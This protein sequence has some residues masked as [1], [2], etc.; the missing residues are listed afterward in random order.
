MAPLG[1]S[2]SDNYR[3]LV[4]LVRSKSLQ[5]PDHICF[6]YL[7]GGGR[8][9]I[10]LTYRQIDKMAMVIAARLQQVCAPGE[11]VLL[12]YPSGLD[13]IP[14][15][16][17]CLYAG[18]IAVPC[19]PPKSKSDLSTLQR[20]A[21]D[22]NSHL[23]LTNQ[24]ILKNDQLQLDQAT[25]LNNLAWI[26]TDQIFGEEIT[27]GWKEADISGNTIACIMYTSGSTR[28]P[29]GVMLTHDN[30]LK[31]GT[32][33]LHDFE[34]GEKDILLCWVSYY[35]VMGL[36]SA[37]LVPI[38]RDIPVILFPPESFAE[39]PMRWLEAMSDYKATISFAPTFAYE[40]CASSKKPQDQLSLDLSCWRLAGTGTEPVRYET[41]MKFTDTF[42]DYGFHREA[43]YSGYGLTE[44]T[45]LATSKRIFDGSGFLSIQRSG[46]NENRAIEANDDSTD[47][48]KLVSVGKALLHQNVRIIDPLKQS[49]CDPGEIGEI[50]ISGPCVAR[51]YWNKPRETKEIFGAYTSDT[52]EG[53]FLRTGDLGFLKNGELFITGRYKDLV[54]IRGKKH[55]PSDIE[56]SAQS[57]HPHIQPGG[58]AAFSIPLDGQEQL[59]IVLEHKRDIESVDVDAIAQSVRSAVAQA[60]YLSVYAVVVV[61]PGSIPRTGIGK[62]QR[63]RCRDN[64]LSSRI[65]AIGIS[66]LTARSA[67]LT[68]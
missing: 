3:T 50:W 10:Q 67:K 16:F 53:P 66:Y 60:H 36:I 48:I 12:I 39:R 68:R 54:I 56:M 33:I 29:A 6:T 17:G 64:F 14:A 1:Y 37:V 63:F 49:S 25:E 28:A 20:I 46:M 18:V 42:S 9:T 44:A 2:S 61:P 4:D 26:T 52:G 13:F 38:P 21:D 31:N 5:K 32:A 35:H 7:I 62:I 11:R 30:I 59:V 19:Y 24:L 41:I 22:C 65:T 57:S 51:G 43:F 27:T 15:F 8:E 23:V 34:F 55:Y 45:V 47:A 40:M 58:G